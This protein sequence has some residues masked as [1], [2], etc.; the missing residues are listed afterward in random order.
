MKRLRRILPILRQQQR[1]IMGGL[2]A[3]LLL[4]WVDRKSVV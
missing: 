3:L 2:T 1:A 4:V